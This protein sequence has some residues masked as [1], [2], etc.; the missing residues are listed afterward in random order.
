MS[1][2][3]TGCILAVI[4]LSLTGCVAQG[5]LDRT[6]TLY[7]QAQ[8]DIVDL[9]DQ[10]DERDRRIAAL[11]ASERGDADTRQQLEQ[12]RADRDQLQAALARA[13]SQL[14]QLAAQ[15][16]TVLPADL[17]SALQ[18]LADAHS[19]I[20][21]YDSDRGMVRFR[22]DLTF[23][24][25]SAQVRSDAEQTL[26][27][28]ASVLNSSSAQAFEVRIVGHTDSVPIGNPETRRNHPTNWHL[29]AHRAI[30]VKDTLEK[31]GVVPARMSVAGYGPYRPVVENR[32]TGAEPNRRVEIFLVAM[33]DADADAYQRGRQVRE[34][35]AGAATTSAP[36]APATAPEE[37]K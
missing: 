15:P 32:P 2:R 31:A 13:Q 12:L 16:A 25:G 10:L 23:P 7:R 30:S 28:L 19:D 9:K 20:M 5:E 36:S 21:S 11:E 6:Q 37:F 4:A 35:S 22:S 29:S 17:D 3:T 26:S 8:N 24:S 18:N 34:T 27:R 1:L 33:T 14:E